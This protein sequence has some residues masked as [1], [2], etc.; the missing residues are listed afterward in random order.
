ME[1][2]EENKM[3][4]DFPNQETKYQQVVEEMKQLVPFLTEEM[5][6]CPDD[7]LI[8][9]L[10]ETVDFY[11]LK[12]KIKFKS[13]ELS[14]NDSQTLQFKEKLISSL[15]NFDSFIIVPNIKNNS[16][17]REF[18][19]NKGNKFISPKVFDING[20]EGYIN[21]EP[22]EKIIFLYDNINDLEIF[23]HKNID[24]N[25]KC[26]CLGVNINFFDTKTLIK[27]L[28]LLDKNNFYFYFATNKP[29][30]NSN[31]NFFNLPRLVRVGEDN[32]IIEDKNIKN[33]RGFDVTKQLM[34]KSKDEEKGKVEDYNFI[35]LENNNK[36]KIIKAIN[37]YIKSAGLNDVHFYV[38]SK[39]SIDKNGI[40]KSRC[41]PTFYGETNKLG[42]FMVN[43]LINILNKQELFNEV[44]NKVNY[45]SEK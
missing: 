40:I 39:I 16:S 32:I 15:S 23:I 17:K 1:T 6:G 42:I 11:S 13:K 7:N 5:K 45:D 22:K 44:Q 14:S 2:K 8:F 24:N 18:Q 26:F 29:E 30:N 21:G 20:D 36:R 31:L 10:I 35:I 12:R 27:N 19:N 37:I 38:K 4:L 9:N 43:N 33:L 34:K 28:G 3:L 41:Y 25:L